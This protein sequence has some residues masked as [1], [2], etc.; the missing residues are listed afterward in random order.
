MPFY[1][2]NGLRVHLNLGR[3]PK[4]WPKPCMATVEREGVSCRCQG[5]S[6]LLCDWPVGEATCD[7]PVCAEHGTEVGKNLHYCPKHLA[8]HRAA[9]P[10]LF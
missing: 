10:E 2:V 8:E 7:M 5:I 9:A 3:N 6:T 1:I 4:K